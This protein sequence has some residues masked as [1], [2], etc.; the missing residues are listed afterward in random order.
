VCGPGFTGVDCN[1]KLL[2]LKAEKVI[3]K[4]ASVPSKNM[5]L[6]VGKSQHGQAYVPPHKK[7]ALP[8][9]TGD[10]FGIPAVN[11][12]GHTGV[13]SS[14]CDDNCNFRGVCRDGECFCQPGFYGKKCGM[15][16]TSEKGTVSLMV[17]LLIGGGCAVVSF[18]M[19]TLLLHLSMQSKRAKETELGYNI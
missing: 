16:K 5:S 11:D 18:S 9:P 4:A 2:G 12:I 10:Q 13:Q 7:H 6:L 14:K 3:V 19:M 15:V 8:P 17:L 1:I